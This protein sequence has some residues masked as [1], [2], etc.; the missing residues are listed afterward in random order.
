MAMEVILSVAPPVFVSVT[1][2]GEEG[3]LTGTRPKE[4]LEGER[5]TAGEPPPASH[6]AFASMMQFPQPAC[7][8]M[9]LPL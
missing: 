3:E 9:S 5:E 2:S 1:V 4:R 6:R 7:V 8:S